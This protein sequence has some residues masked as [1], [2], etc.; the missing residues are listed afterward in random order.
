MEESLEVKVRDSERIAWAERFALIC[1]ALQGWRNSE[2]FEGERP[3]VEV[4]L[5]L[6]IRRFE[7]VEMAEGQRRKLRY[8]VGISG[9][10]Q[11]FY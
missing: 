11:R 7:E 10:G 9:E 4:K 8:D 1:W 2:I 3:S 5:Q 6:L